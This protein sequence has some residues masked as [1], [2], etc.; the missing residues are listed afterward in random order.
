MNLNN[1]TSYIF[2]IQNI[3][4]KL[5]VIFTKGSVT[6]KNKILFPIPH[7]VAAQ[8]V[9]AISTELGNGQTRELSEAET[10][11]IQDVDKLQANISGTQHIVQIAMPIMKTWPKSRR[12]FVSRKIQLWNERELLDV[13]FV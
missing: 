9:Q 4:T 6:K 3:G 13:V 10:V 5:I 1:Q 12:D 2:L 7:A 11:Q 8:I